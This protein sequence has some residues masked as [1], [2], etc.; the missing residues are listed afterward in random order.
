MSTVTKQVARTR[1]RLAASLFFQQFAFALLMAA[2]A[3]A[4]VTLTVRLTALELPVWIVGGG[5]AGLALLVAIIATFAT[6]PSALT[7]A[8]ALDRAAGLKE[9]ISTAI[10]IERLDD[11]FAR[12]AVS[13]AERIAGSLHV[14]SHIRLNAPSLWPWSAASIIA[15]IC[16][17]AF[18]PSVDLFAKTKEDP[19]P[20][21]R[22][23]AVQEHQAIKAEF[24]KEA[25]RLA[26][27]E[28]GNPAL[29]DVADKLEKL[30]LPEAAN[31]SPDDVRREAVRRIDNVQD[32]L[33]SQLESDAASQLEQTKRLL[34]ELEQPGELPKPTTP[35][36]NALANGNFDDAKK[37]LDKLAEDIKEAAQNA[38]DP[39]AKKKLEETQKQ[40]NELSEKLKQLDDSKRM[41]KELEHKAG[42]SEDEAKKLMDQLSKMDPNQIADALKKQLDGKGLSEQ[43]LKELAKKLQQSQAAQ[44]AAKEL[45]KKLSQAAEQAGKCQ[46]P[47][48][49]G[50][51]SDSASESLGDAGEMLSEMEMQEEMMKE[52]K[53]QADRLGKLR[54]DLSCGRKPGE[55]EGDEQPGGQGPEYGHGYGARIGE[56]KTPHATTPE[57]ANVKTKGGQ[58]IG[59]MLVNGPAYR[60]E[61]TA[62]ELAAAQA[63]VHDALEAVEREDVP[64]QYQRVVQEYFDRL[65]GLAGEREKSASPTT[66]PSP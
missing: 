10:A 37:Q 6:R 9:R 11:P 19:A 64:R 42:L 34:S 20:Q 14:P 25:R 7:S 63:E 59:R 31:L 17:A 3:W 54:D 52:L 41:Q 44:Q 16:V 53:S 22:S 30:D 39:E 66:Q 43:Q 55:G 50:D 24:D 45:A 61:A 51:A 5:V 33:R 27:L 29:K 32:T 1:A 12:A 65:A 4:L 38:A 28:Q 47:G 40:L 8:V 58:V 35:I 49:A 26:E 48:D 15:A 56:K 13:D 23:M 60:G 18:T 36:E 2:G 62:E 46:N 57:K 21:L